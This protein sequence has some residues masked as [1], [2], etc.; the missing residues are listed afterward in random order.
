M[1]EFEV[2]CTDCGAVLDAVFNGYGPVLEVTPCQTCMDVANDKGYQ[3]GLEE[4]ED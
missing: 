4:A 1:A 2:K 3:A